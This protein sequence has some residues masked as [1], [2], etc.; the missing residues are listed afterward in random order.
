MFALDTRLWWHRTEVRGGGGLCVSVARDVYLKKQEEEEEEEKEEE[1][2][3][4]GDTKVTNL[5]CIY[6]TVDTSVG[7]LL[8][9]EGD[10]PD[11]ELGRSEKPN[12][13]VVDV[14]VDGEE[15]MGVVTNR[16]VKEGE[17]FTVCYS[18]EEEEEG[19]EEGE[20]EEE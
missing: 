13:E 9:T 12:C 20:E 7:T 6:A 14:E 15:I 2:G 10:M 16:D 3:G 18:S 1:D 5:D 19:D 11:C 4:E 8:F 17:V